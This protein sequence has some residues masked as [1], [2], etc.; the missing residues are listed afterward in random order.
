MHTYIYNWSLSSLAISS[1]WPELLL[2]PH[3]HKGTEAQSWAMVVCAV[4]LWFLLCF[5]RAILRWSI[6]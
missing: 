4:A 2:F 5:H 6:P 1:F 3:G